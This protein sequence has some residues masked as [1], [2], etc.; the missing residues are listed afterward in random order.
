MK[1]IFYLIQISLFISSINI[2]SNNTDSLLI[3]ND[4][5]TPVPFSSSNLPIVVI[6][7]NGQT[8]VSE[9]KI[10][11]DM[12]IIDNGEGVRNYLTDAFN[13]YDG[14]IG[15]EI[16]GSTSQ[17]FPKKQYGF[18]TRDSIGNNLNVP[19]LGFPAEN[20]WILS[21]PYNDKSLIRDVLVYKLSNDMG[22][23][24]SRSRYCELVLNG[25]YVGIYILLE[26]IK[27]DGNRVNIKK[28]EPP[29][30]TGDALTGG[31]IIKIDKMDGENN[32]FWYSS[33]LP[34][35]NA[36]YMIPYIY[37][38]PKPDEIVP[39][40]MTYIQNRIFFFETMM[41]YGI[42]IADTATG[43][44]KFLD[45]DSFVDFV[46]LNETAKNVDGYRLSTYLHKDRDSRSTKISAGPVWD[47]N[48]A[49]GNADYYNGGSSAGWE[50]EFL[51]NPNNMPANEP[52]LTPFWWKK[53]F[54]DSQFRDRV[55][56]RWQVL[57]NSVLNTEHIYNYIDSLT[58]L[59]DESK[60]R[61]FQ[62][63]PVLGVYVWPN[64]FVGS[65]YESE[66]I[67]LKT[68][69]YNRL[70]WMNQ[71]MIGGPTALNEESESMPS[72]FWLEQNYPNPFNNSTKIK[73]S[74]SQNSQVVIKII[75]ILG[76]DIATLMDEKKSVGTYEISWNAAAINGGL[77]SG[78]Y[79]YQLRAAP[80][81]V[82]AGDFVETKKM[83]LMK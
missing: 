68:W 27:R 81:G 17:W 51:S 56:A 21:A 29:D 44:P 48:I 23:Y 43:Y 20:D 73:Y 25:E 22:H 19:L 64:Y 16:R 24:A 6:N 28:L 35:P 30:T 49:L 69:I 67:Y 41:M 38:Y 8:I 80:Y 77:P 31:Y 70:Y 53:L 9:Y 34:F 59:L 11:V 10:T 14:K 1:K 76:N 36:P 7:T 46:L 2:F 40:Q 47:F 61:N 18:E 74:V 62:K 57:K 15:I 82:Q 78:V 33:Y 12:G 75:D 66:I 42:N 5:L 52:F 37:H 13:N 4:Q 65:D 83:I 63:W 71:N 60:T 39:R 79:F 26:K 58:T 3:Q 54:A 55:Y 45:V 32:E 50:I 72:V